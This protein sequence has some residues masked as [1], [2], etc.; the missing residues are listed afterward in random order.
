MSV[1]DADE[2]F[3]DF[4]RH[5]GNLSGQAIR[6]K[7][8]MSAKAWNHI[9]SKLELYK[10]SHVFSPHTAET[11]SEDELDERVEEVMG[12][13]FDDRVVNRMVVTGEKLFK[14]ESERAMKFLYNAEYRL[15]IIKQVIE[16]TPSLDYTAPKVEI[17]NNEEVTFM[18]GD[19]HY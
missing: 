1:Q 19:I 7:Y 5:G 17:G 8:G 3:A 16:S 9:K 10:D 2:L 12:T 15:D 6:Q 13:H 11:L 18:F 4:S 14:K